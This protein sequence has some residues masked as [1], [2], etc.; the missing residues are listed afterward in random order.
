MI[1]VLDRGFDP[2]LPTD[3]KYTFIV[4]LDS[5]ITFQ[6][7]PYSAVALI[8]TGHMDLFNLLSDSFVF[9]LTSRDASVKPFIVC[10]TAYLSQLAKNSYWITIRFVFFLDCLID[11]SMPDQAQPRLLSISSI[12]FRKDASISARSF[13]ARRILFSA[14]SFSSSDI[15]SNGFVRPRLSLRASIP[16]ASYLTV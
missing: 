10:R 4:C 7:I 8:R 15:S 13:S 14:R 2:F 3:P 1:R 12:F 11:V 16:S 5:M 9:C 6:I